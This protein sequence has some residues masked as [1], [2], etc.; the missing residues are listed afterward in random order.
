MR[1][2]QDRA[3][4]AK[5]VEIGELVVDKRLVGERLFESPGLASCTPVRLILAAPIAPHWPAQTTRNFAGTLHALCLL[6]RPLHGRHASR[7]EGTK[8]LIDE[9]ERFGVTAVDIDS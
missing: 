2:A 1:L 8:T 3:L 7:G 4:G 9:F 5:G 6:E